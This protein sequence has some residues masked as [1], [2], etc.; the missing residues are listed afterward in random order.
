VL[1]NRQDCKLIYADLGKT[2]QVISFLSAIMKKH[3][4]R[5][6]VDRRARHTQSLLDRGYKIPRSS[7][8]MYELRIPRPNEM[9]PTCLLVAPAVL[10][11]NWRNE[12]ET[13]SSREHLVPIQR[14]TSCDS[15]ATLSLR[16]VAPEI[17]KTLFD[18]SV[19]VVWI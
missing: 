4:D 13:V 1:F 2:V 8:D 12:L 16:Y 18:N 9:W 14:L 17:W 10:L 7:I 15:G 6:D 11:S 19:T 3:A 5:R